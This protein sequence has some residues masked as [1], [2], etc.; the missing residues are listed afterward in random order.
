MPPC[1]EGPRPPAL[2]YAPSRCRRHLETSPKHA[3]HI[4]H[5]LLS[6]SPAKSIQTRL[7]LLVC[8]WDPVEK[9]K[10]LGLTMVMKATMSPGK[11]VPASKESC[12]CR[13][14]R[15]GGGH[16]LKYDSKSGEII[17]DECN[18]FG[19]SPDQYEELKRS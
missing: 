4:N 8:V 5:L 10:P 13:G 2:P 12:L 3:L 6:T 9:N 17:S 15:G 1:A 16:Q 19:S 18:Y 14:V 7:K 11:Y